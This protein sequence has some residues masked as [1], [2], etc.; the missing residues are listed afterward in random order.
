M[1]IDRFIVT[2][3][4]N[5]SF[6]DLNFSS[7]F[8]LIYGENGSGKTSLL[9]AIYYLGH[10]RSFRSHL[11]QRIVQHGKDKLVLFAELGDKKLGLER[12]L[13]LKSQIHLN[14]ETINTILPITEMLPIQ[15]IDSKTFQLLDSV[16]ENRR[17][18]LDWGVFHMEHQYSSLWKKF[19]R[20]LKQRNHAL[21][22]RLPVNE[23]KMW[24]EP[25][26]IAANKIN[27]LRKA[28]FKGVSEC[29]AVNNALF[30]FGN[31]D[32]QYKQGWNEE[33]LLEEH[34]EKNLSTD[35]RF[36]YTQCGPQRADIKITVNSVPAKDVLSRGQQKFLISCMKTSQLQYLF[37]RTSK[38]ALLLLDDLPSELDNS[39]QMALVSR[40]KEVSGQMF[41]TSI[42]KASVYDCLEEKSSTFHVEHGTVVSES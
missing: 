13:N 39:R 40:L 18:F 25:F 7:K 26:A 16:P 30:D 4:R 3:F 19:Q 42:D 8:N 36:G 23:V 22:A 1:S 29:F 38:R 2:D 20:I 17:Q 15:I 11:K 33:F 5:I 41:I 6:A 14:E 10:N 21:K 37:D 12:S 35:M 24:N 32:Y 28:Y 9:E 34:L 27:A 31:I